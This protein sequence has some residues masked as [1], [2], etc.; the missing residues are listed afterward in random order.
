M[1]DMLRKA[2]QEH[3]AVMAINCFNLETMRSVI[4]AAQ[5]MHS[6]IIINILQDH[7][8]R[9]GDPEIFAWL[10]AHIAKK[11]TVDVALNVDHGSD[12]ELLKAALDAGFTS[13]MAD[14]S[15]MDLEENIQA[16]REIVQYAHDRGATVE[17]ELGGIGDACGHQTDEDMKTNPQMA[18]RFAEETGIDCLA[19]SYGSSHGTYPDGFIPPFDIKRLKEIHGAVSVPL[20]LHGGSGSGQKNIENSVANGI[21][22]I[23]VGCDFMNGTRDG[24][25][26]LL[27]DDPNINYF[28]LIHRTEPAGQDVIRQY[29]RWAGSE[30]KAA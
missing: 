18:S 25:I 8:L 16:T 7:L 27:Q 5:S 26:H 24:V 11:A 3:Y 9:H 6:P 2:Q 30:G 21:C 19:V 4:E 12:A 1:K 23:N 22:K 17:A 10:A 29:I 13:V 15:A 14:F 28:E 20:V